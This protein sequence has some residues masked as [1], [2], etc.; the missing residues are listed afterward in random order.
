MGFAV[1]CWLLKPSAA[2]S[3][4]PAVL[5]LPAHQ[6]QRSAVAVST[7]HIPAASLAPHCPRHV[8][9]PKE[10]RQERHERPSVHYVTEIAQLNLAFRS[11]RLNVFPATPTLVTFDIH[12]SRPFL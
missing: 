3:S 6:A 11:S 2:G 12:I 10:S 8:Q 1:R 9:E 7:G 4:S 5:Q